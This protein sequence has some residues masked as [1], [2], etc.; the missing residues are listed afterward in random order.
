LLNCTSL[1]CHNECTSGGGDAGTGGTTLASAIAQTAATICGKMRDC[2]PGLLAW[3]FGTYD[4]CVTRSVALDT[5]V[6]GL[7]DVSL[8]A[9]TYTAC[10]NAYA[11][12]SCSQFVGADPNECW[13]PGNRANGQ[14]CNAGDQ[15]ASM[16][17]KQNAWSCGTCAP[18]PA[19][20][21]ACLYAADCGRGTW[22]TAG[23]CQKPRLLGETCTT[24]LPCS[25]ELVCDT[26]KCA[27][28]PAVQEAS[29][30]A[31][32]GRYCSWTQS[33]YCA[34][35]GKCVTTTWVA[36]GQTCSASTTSASLCQKSGSCTSGIC[37]A[38]PADHNACDPADDKCEW[39]AVC[40]SAKTCLVP[41][42]API[43]AK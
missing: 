29:C 3:R 18:M 25:N 33:L 38:A 12:V 26:D 11:A 16:F 27:A 1:H 23:T 31:A 42:D 24:D 10:G 13:T 7:A 37:V 39:P 14:G 9:S 34:S 21:A 41:S 40:S 32:V 19:V 30:D 5:F 35:N 28:A 36:T 43:C 22:C 4:E 17:C 2:S 6:S 15:C 8:S 20:G